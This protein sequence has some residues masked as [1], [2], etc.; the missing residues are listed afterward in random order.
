MLQILLNFS[1]SCNLMELVS[2]FFHRWLS[3]SIFTLVSVCFEAQQSSLFSQQKAVS[4]FIQNNLL[5][6]TIFMTLRAWGILRIHT[7]TI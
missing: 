6:I 3:A 5:E 7:F 2:F 1:V 4:N